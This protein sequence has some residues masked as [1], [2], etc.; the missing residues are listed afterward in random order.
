GGVPMRTTGGSGTRT[1][2]DGLEG[3]P[4][5]GLGSIAS[6]ASGDRTAVWSR[7]GPG[8]GNGS[9]KD[10]VSFERG[11][12]SRRIVWRASSDSSTGGTTVRSGPDDG[13]GVEWSPKCRLSRSCALGVG[14][15]ETF[16][17]ESRIVEI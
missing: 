7:N 4:A 16:G 13:D 5:A 15:S 1:G 12:R 14:M 17:E 2:A 6:T 10:G 3:A 8:A 9:G 11:E